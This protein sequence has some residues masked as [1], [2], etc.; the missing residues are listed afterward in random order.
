MTDWLTAKQASVRLFGSDR[1]G[2]YLRTL[3][4][5]NDGRLTYRLKNPAAVRRIYLIS[6]ASVDAY[7]A[8]TTRHAA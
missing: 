3:A 8:N 7:I 1:P 6:A 5:V 4:L 2:D